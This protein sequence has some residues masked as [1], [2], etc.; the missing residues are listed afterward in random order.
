[1]FKT[2]KVTHIYQN[3]ELMSMSSEER[4]YK[5]PYDFLEALRDV[6]WD[7]TIQ[8]E[9]DEIYSDEFERRETHWFLEQTGSKSSRIRLA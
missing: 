5:N 3:D 8:A 1:M 6:R 9:A 2:I 7:M 4:I